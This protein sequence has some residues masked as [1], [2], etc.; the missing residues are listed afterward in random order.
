MYY[1]DETSIR[2]VF[3]R[4]LYD[5]YEPC[6]CLAG[7]PEKRERGYVAKLESAGTNWT[8]HIPKILKGGDVVP[9]SPC[10]M[11]ST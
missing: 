5:R 9:G 10:S 7:N 2:E 8:T 1:D 6:R 11:H 4:H 3:H